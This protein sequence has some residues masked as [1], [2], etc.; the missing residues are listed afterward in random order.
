MIT[1][2]FGKL[3]GETKVSSVISRDFGG[4]NQVVGTQWILGV[5][6]VVGTWCKVKIMNFYFLKIFFIKK[7]FVTVKFTCTL[8]VRSENKS[9]VTWHM[10]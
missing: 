5:D 6:H 9:P 10:E 8:H 4:L 7:I 3:P 1:A 2:I